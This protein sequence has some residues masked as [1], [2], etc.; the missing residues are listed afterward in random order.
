MR[1]F[2]SADSD[3]MILD[4][5]EN[6]NEIYKELVEFTESEKQKVKINAIVKGNPEPYSEFLPYIELSKS[7]GK[8]LVRFSEDRGLVITGS[9]AYLIKYIEAFRFS[10]DEDGNH[11]HPE[12]ELVNENS[13]SMG[14]LWPFIEADNDYVAE[15]QAFAS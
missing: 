13:F 7:E 8:V 6:L 15:H 14:G 11:H 4:S 5:V 2:Y 9:T 12:F 3:P 1:I 10:S